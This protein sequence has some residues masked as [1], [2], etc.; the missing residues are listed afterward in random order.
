MSLKYDRLRCAGA[1]IQRV[2]SE[3]PKS[4]VMTYG[5][6]ND[7]YVKGHAQSAPSKASTSGNKAG[8]PNKL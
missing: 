1:K 5:T 4:P 2:S 3:L 6:G 7:M 8:I